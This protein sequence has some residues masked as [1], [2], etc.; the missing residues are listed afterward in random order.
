MTAGGAVCPLTQGLA[1][2]GWTVGRNVRMD[3]RWAISG[4]IEW[5]GASSGKVQ[6]R[7]T[8]SFSLCW[9]SVSFWQLVPRERSK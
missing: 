4:E 6:R 1:D 2:L 8:L 3:L 5:T 9:P 7:S